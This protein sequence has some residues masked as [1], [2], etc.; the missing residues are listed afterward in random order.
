M[1]A[2]AG[3]ASPL[4]QCSKGYQTPRYPLLLMAGKEWVTLGSCLGKCSLVPLHSFVHSLKTSLGKMGLKIQNQLSPLHGWLYTQHKLHAPSPSLK[5]HSQGD[6]W[7]PTLLSPNFLPSSADSPPQILW[8][9]QRPPNVDKQ[10]LF[11]YNKVV[12]HCHWHEAE[13]QRQARVG[14]HFFS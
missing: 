4:A 3:Q 12:S 2:R 7:F 8:N 14:N 10:W 1:Y 13:T 5:C 11:I 6:C 9:K